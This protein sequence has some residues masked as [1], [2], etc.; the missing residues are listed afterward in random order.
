MASS[1]TYNQVKDSILHKNF[2][3]VY[4]LTGEESFYIDKLTQ[5]FEENIDESTKDFNCNILYGKDTD[6]QNLESAIGSILLIRIAMNV[7]HIYQASMLVLIS[8]NYKK[9]ENIHNKNI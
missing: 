5:C 1:A 4:L 3:P 6:R 8:K 2:A 9:N 7:L